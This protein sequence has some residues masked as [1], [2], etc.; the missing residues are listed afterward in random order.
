MKKVLIII[1]AA[2]VFLAAAEGDTQIEIIERAG[3]TDSGNANLSIGF[4]AQDL[5][6]LHAALLE[7]G[8]EPTDYASP[9]PQVRFFFVKDPAGV[10]VQFM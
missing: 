7:A 5:D 4:V 6:A 9:M 10:N 2:V 1:A 3:T 8:F